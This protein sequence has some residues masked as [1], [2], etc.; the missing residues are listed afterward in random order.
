MSGRHPSAFEA[1]SSQPPKPQLQV[2]VHAGPLA[3][4]GFPITGDKITFGR[5]PNNNISWDDHQVSR[6]HAQLMRRGDQHI[7]C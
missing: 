5:D 7:V 6:H 3:G 2:V 4:K 1:E